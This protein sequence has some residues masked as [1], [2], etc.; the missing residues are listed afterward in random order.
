MEFQ[1]LQSKNILLNSSGF[2][3]LIS[4]VPRFPR[5][6]DRMGNFLL[7]VRNWEASPFLFFPLSFGLSPCLKIGIGNAYMKHHKAMNLLFLLPLA[8]WR[9]K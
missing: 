6:G 8:R 5:P 9:R 7:S 1:R 3:H 2:N 4:F